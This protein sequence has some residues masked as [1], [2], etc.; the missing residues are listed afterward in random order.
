MGTSISASV[1][2]PVS[3]STA[4]EN[5]ADEREI[6]EN[7]GLDCTGFIIVDAGECSYETKARN[8]E[9]MGAAAVIIME[10]EPLSDLEG[11]AEDLMA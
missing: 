9:T 11:T 3:S 6:A 1:Y 8:I 2:H 10:N 7:L 4:C 5:M